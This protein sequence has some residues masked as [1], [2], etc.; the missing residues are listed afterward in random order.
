MRVSHTLIFLLTVLVGNSAF[1]QDAPPAQPQAPVDPEIELNLVNLPTTRSLG[2]HKSYTRFTHRFSRDLGLGDFGDLASDL[3]SLDNG[4]VIGLE[5]RFGITSAIQAGLHRNTLDKT[6]QLFSRWDAARQGGRLPVSLS[7]FASIEGLDNLQDGRQ[8]GVGAV[9]SFIRGQSLALYASPTFVD[10]TR[11]AGLLGGVPHEHE[12]DVV[13]APGIVI[14]PQGEDDHA[15]HDGTFF[16][17][18]GGRLRL[19]PSVFV[20]GEIS[21]RLAGHDPGDPGWGVSLE[22]STRGHTL[23][24]TLTNFFGTTPGQIAR[25]GTNALY[26]GFNITRKF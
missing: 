12:H 1:A 26:L 21:P 11:E 19:R 7:A 6:L 13:P 20:V 23:A 10:G 5:Y 2:R 16:V 18:L 3:F 15:H 17:G 25:G 14:D 4:A 8:P 9:V 24:L 22:K